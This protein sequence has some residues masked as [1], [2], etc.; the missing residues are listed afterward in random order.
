MVIYPIC[1]TIRRTTAPNDVNKCV[2]GWNGGRKPTRQ[3]LAAGRRA[4]KHVGKESEKEPPRAQAGFLSQPASLREREREENRR[5]LVPMASPIKDERAPPP[6]PIS[7]PIF[8]LST[9]HSTR[10]PPKPHASFTASGNHRNGLAIAFPT[11]RFTSLYCFD[12]RLMKRTR[13]PR[14]RSVSQDD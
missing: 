1:R 10:P 14:G 6:P 2:E 4:R 9:F 13:R 7:F 12:H 3:S 8:I 5:G 11:A